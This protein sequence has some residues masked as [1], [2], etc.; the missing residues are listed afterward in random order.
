MIK[1]E[2]LR[3][4]GARIIIYTDGAARGNP[5]PAGWAA[6]IIFGKKIF[7]DI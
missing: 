2:K 3:Q 5:G 7:T 4:G 1:K 6:I